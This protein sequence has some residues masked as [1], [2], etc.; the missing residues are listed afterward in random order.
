M[1]ELLKKLQGR[2]WYHQR[3]DGAP[4]YLSMVGTAETFREERKPVG[5][6]ALWRVCFYAEGSADWYLDQEDID[7]GAAIVTKLC[8][9]SADASG[10][11]MRKWE[12]D[13]RA[14]QEYFDQF[15]PQR[16]AGM[17]DQELVN[18][19]RLYRDLAFRRFS[20]SSIIDHF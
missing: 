11:L 14:F 20:S 9:T 15:K 7:R 2:H 5:T 17:S 6:Q 1:D 16:L 4:L 19:Y 10:E 12:L 8:E 13:E 18:E 3:F